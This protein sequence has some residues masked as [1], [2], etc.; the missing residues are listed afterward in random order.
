MTLTY[1]SEAYLKNLLRGKNDNYSTGC[2]NFLPIQRQIHEFDCTI[3]KHM[4]Y[5]YKEEKCRGNVY[6]TSY[7]EEKELKYA[8]RKAKVIYLRLFEKKDPN[9][10][11][12]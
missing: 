4:L 12:N 6:V 8:L 5:S 3:C 1:H 2:K 7:I 10:K 11:N 9:V